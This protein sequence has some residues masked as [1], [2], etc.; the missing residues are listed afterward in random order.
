LIAALNRND[1]HHRWALK[2]IEAHR[3]SSKPIV[4]PQ[5]VAGEAFTKL[6]YDRRV[7]TR[8]DARPALMVFGLLSSDRSLFELRS[9][10]VESYRRTVALLASYVDQAFSWIDAVVLLTA[11]DDRRIERLWT[12]DASLAAYAFS[13]QV[14]VSTPGH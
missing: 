10:P 11:E 3:E 9:L 4:V 5:V 13:H 1:R 14:V 2:A 7:S 8:G 12:V 6:R